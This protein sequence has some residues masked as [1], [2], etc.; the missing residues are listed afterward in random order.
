MVYYVLEA[1]PAHFNPN[2]EGFY[3]INSTHPSLAGKY[4]KRFTGISNSQTLIGG[5]QLR[6]GDVFRFKVV[7]EDCNKE[8]ELAPVEVKNSSR[9]GTLNNSTM[10]SCKADKNGS[11]FASWFMYTGGLDI[12]EIK[13]VNFDG[14]ATQLPTGFSL[15]YVVNDKDRISSSGQNWILRDLPIGKYTYVYTDV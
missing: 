9:R 15:P 5:D 6:I 4:V 13:I 3:K 2:T 8:V 1:Y 12:A 14:D 10:G 7:S 11:N